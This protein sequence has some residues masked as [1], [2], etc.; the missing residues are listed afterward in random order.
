[1]NKDKKK[2]IRL[3]THKLRALFCILN[4]QHIQLNDVIRLDNDSVGNVFEIYG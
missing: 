2:D 4:A 1:M 3:N